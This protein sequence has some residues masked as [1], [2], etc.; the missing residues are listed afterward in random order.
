VPYEAL[1]S[2][3]AGAG[4]PTVSAEPSAVSEASQA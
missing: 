4:A 1:E 3:V 2:S